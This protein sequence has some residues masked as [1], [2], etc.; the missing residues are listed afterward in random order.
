MF[1]IL[2]ILRGNDV[3]PDP[4]DQAILAACK[5]Q[6]L[7]VAR[8]IG[9]VANALN[10]STRV[11]ESEDPRGRDA[12]FDFIADRIKALV[13]AKKLESAGNLGRWGWSE[14]RLTGK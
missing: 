14:I 12:E 1:P 5:P 2:F 13:K 10:V 11:E 7:K 9:D 8:I 4:I 3:S 6:F